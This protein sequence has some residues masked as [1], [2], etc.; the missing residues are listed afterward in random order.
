VTGKQTKIWSG[1]IE[2]HITADIAFAV[3]QYYKITNDQE[4]MNLYG[5]EI[6]FDTASFWASRLEWNEQKQ[7]Y[8]I[9][10]VV[11]PDEYK[12]HVDNN[13]FT[14][15]MAHFNISLAMKYYEELKGKNPEILEGLESKLKL[16]DSYKSWEEK[17]EKIYLPQPRKEDMVIP[18]DDTYLNKRVIDLEK[19]KNQSK[20][21]TLFNDYNLEQ[22]NEIQVSKQAD[23]MILFLILERCG[24]RSK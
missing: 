20:V 24:T 17:L 8:Q 1:F 10:N 11:G 9:N 4:F 14:N 23:I 7:E 22:V 6:I 18:Q 15:H 13:A 21:G 3:W 5:Y 19:Y 12:E 2:Q 16:T